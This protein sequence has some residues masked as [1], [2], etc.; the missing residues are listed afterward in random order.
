[1]DKIKSREIKLQAINRLKKEHHDRLV[2]IE[3]E[4][5]E[6]IEEDIKRIERVNDPHLKGGGMDVP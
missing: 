3:A 1:M 2:Q 6:L 4:G 5:G